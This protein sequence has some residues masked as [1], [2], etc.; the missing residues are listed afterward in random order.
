MSSSSS[1]N[2]GPSFLTNIIDGLIINGQPSSRRG[3]SV[4]EECETVYPS[5]VSTARWTEYYGDEETGLYY[6][7]LAP[8]DIL[9]LEGYNPDLAGGEVDPVILA[10]DYET[11]SDNVDEASLLGLFEPRVYSPVDETTRPANT[12]AYAVVIECCPEKYDTILKGT[13]DPGSDIFE[14]SAMLKQGVCNATETAAIERRKRRREQELVS[15]EDIDKLDAYAFAMDP[16]SY[17]M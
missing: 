17:T 13:T 5:D 3:L 10:P 4:D 7:E 1:S 2:D 11:S 14:A 12:T 15:M 6:E 9:K 16:D 8:V